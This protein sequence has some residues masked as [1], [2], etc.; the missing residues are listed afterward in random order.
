MVALTAGP[1][2]AKHHEHRA[3]YLANALHGLEPTAARA[4]PEPQK[5]LVRRAGEPLPRCL[6]A[7]AE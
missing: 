5:V 6:P 3:E 1:K 2:D 4:P 7:D